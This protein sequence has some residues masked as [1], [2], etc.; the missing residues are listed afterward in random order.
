MCKSNHYGIYLKIIQA[1]SQFYFNETGR[2]KKRIEKGK[3]I[4]VER[5]IGIYDKEKMTQVLV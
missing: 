5:E 3:H 4:K 2:K 1:L